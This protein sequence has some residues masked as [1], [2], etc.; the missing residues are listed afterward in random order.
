MPTDSDSAVAPSDDTLR[1]EQAFQDDL[2][3]KRLPDWLHELADA[4]LAALCAA[5][6][7]SLDCRQ[8]LRARW[9]R[10][11]GIEAFVGAAL[12]DAFDKRFA[13]KVDVATRGSAT[14]TRCRCVASIS[15]P[16]FRFRILTMPRLH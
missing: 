6:K 9:R 10:V 1:F 2:I 14:G 3:A 16:E 8:R 5:L 4:S 11:Q 12:Q 13:T 7:T 15:L